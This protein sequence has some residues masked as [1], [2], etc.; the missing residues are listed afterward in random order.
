M[1]FFHF[2]IKKY[3]EIR[4][5]D[6]VP[7]NKALGYAALIKGIVYSQRNMEILEKELSETNDLVKIQDAVYGIEK[8]GLDAVI[9]RNKTAAEWVSHLVD[10]ASKILPDYERDYLDYV[11]TTGSVSEQKNTDQ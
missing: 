11:R 3:I 9:Y 8:N 5:A 7:I 2:R 1:G 10:L 6:S 4:I